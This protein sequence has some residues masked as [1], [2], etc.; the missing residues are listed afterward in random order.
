MYFPPL[1]MGPSLSPFIASPLYVSLVFFLPFSL[2]LSLDLVMLSLFSLSLCPS[3]FIVAPSFFSQST[4]KARR[5]AGM[6]AIRQ[7]DRLTDI[8]TRTGLFNQ[9]LAGSL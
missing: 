5:L 3:S 7:A 8:H 1:S 2:P 4:K 9:H 6:Q